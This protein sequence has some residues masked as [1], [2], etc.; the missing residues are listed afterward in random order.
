MEKEILTA[1]TTK[2]EGVDAKIL[3][4]IAA[5]LAKT[6]TTTEQVATAVEGVTF[7]Q[8]LENYGDSRANDAQKTAVANY[9]K[10]YGLKD[11]QKTTGAETTE[12]D[13]H[14]D[15]DM[16]A[17]ATKLFDKISA[18]EGVNVTNSRAK[19]LDEQL[20]K[21]PDYLKKAYS[22]VSL[23]DLSDEDFNNLVAEVGE[24]AT[25]YAAEKGTGH[26]FGRPLVTGGGAPQGG[27]P[28]DAQVDNVVSRLKV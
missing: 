23:K 19:T 2:F 1:L 7:Q 5:K 3:G 16:P 26:K 20:G 18:L 28:T 4:R 22:H 9:E 13:P 12:P 21:L 10:K 25:A 6:V 24:A 14:K 8:V 11:G 17:W 27:E 15:D